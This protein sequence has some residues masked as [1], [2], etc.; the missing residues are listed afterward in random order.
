MS[1]GR[2]LPNRTP[3][4]AP[5]PRLG[6]LGANLDGFS[7]RWTWEGYSLRGRVSK[8]QMQDRGLF[9]PGSSPSGLRDLGLLFGSR[10]R[11]HSTSIQGKPILDPA[12]G[13]STPSLSARP[14]FSGPSSRASTAWQRSIP[15]SVRQ[16]ELL[17]DRPTSPDP[18]A[19]DGPAASTLARL[20]LSTVPV[21]RAPS[22]VAAP[23]FKALT[24]LL[25]AMKASQAAFFASR[26]ASNLS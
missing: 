23:S 11:G 1:H 10:R 21:A 7:E 26:A 18:E 19:E 13:P 6:S 2:G 20:V 16:R 14:P 8:V 4:K 22:C 25:A 9:S 12:P 3:G 24:S 17:G 15:E 5:S